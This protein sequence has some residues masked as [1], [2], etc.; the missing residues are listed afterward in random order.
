[1]LNVIQAYTAEATKQAK[2]H[3]RSIAA[4]IAAAVVGVAVVVAAALCRSGDAGTGGEVS[5][6]LQNAH[7]KKDLA[8]KHLHDFQI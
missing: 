6:K 3:S 7:H 4:A 2:F 8:N 5:N 1:M